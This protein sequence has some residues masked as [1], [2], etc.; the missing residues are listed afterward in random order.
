TDLKEGIF[1]LLKN[2]HTI[3]P[4]DERA[5]GHFDL[6]D[7]FKK[8]NGLFLILKAVSFIVGGLVLISGVIG[9]VNIML[10]VVKERTQEIG[11]RRALGAT[12]WVI[13]KQILTESV[14]LCIL[15]G[16][17]GIIGASGLLIIA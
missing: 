10:I 15:S 11:I 6:Y 7:E 17:V 12:P 16:M 5:I 2:R 1:T 8:I 13:R 3:D 9:I 14:I 4:T